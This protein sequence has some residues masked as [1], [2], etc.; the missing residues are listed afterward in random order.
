MARVAIVTGGA[1]GVGRALRAV[2]VRRCDHVVLADID[3]DGLAVPV[4]R[5]PQ[6]LA[7]VPV[8]VR[9]QGVWCG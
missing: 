3:A 8:V 2:L 1:S 7:V 5:A 6:V 9:T 4:M